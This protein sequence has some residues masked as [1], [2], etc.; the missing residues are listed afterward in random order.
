MNAPYVICS[1]CG[2]RLSGYRDGLGEYHVMPHK[3][4]AGGVCPGRTMTDH[5]PERP[6]LV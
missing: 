4:P 5:Q 1:Q 2:R 6:V 3:Q